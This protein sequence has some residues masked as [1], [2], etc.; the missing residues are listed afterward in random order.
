MYM[1]TTNTG[2]ATSIAACLAARERLA[3][4]DTVN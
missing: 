2:G 3:F 4:A 1:L